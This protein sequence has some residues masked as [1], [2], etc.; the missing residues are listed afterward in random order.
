MQWTREHGFGSDQVHLRVDLGLAFSDFGGEARN[1]ARS[2]LIHASQSL[3]S[4]RVKSAKKHSFELRSTTGWG[5]II[6][7]CHLLP[8]ARL[9]VLQSIS[10][11]SAEV[12]PPLLQAETWSA[13]ISFM[14]HI[15]SLL[16]SWPIA[17]REQFHVF[18]A[19]AALV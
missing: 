6:I 9:C 10:Q 19:F 18:L 12:A 15:L 1:S 17:Q 16:A 13:S 8:L 7:L 3:R 14:A 5:E 11:F 2:P 4:D